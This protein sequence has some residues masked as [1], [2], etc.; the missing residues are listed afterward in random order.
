MFKWLFV[1]VA[2]SAITLRNLKMEND[3]TAGKLKITKAAHGLNNGDILLYKVN[4]GTPQTGL[5]DNKAYAV[6]DKTANTFTLKSVTNAEPPVA[7][8]KINGATINQTHQPTLQKMDSWAGLNAAVAGGDTFSVS[9]N[10]APAATTNKT[11]WAAGDKIVFVCTDSGGNKCDTTVPAAG[12]AVFMRDVTAATDSASLKFKI[13]A[14]ATGNALTVNQHADVDDSDNGFYKVSSAA[15]WNPI[16]TTTKAPSWDTTNNKLIGTLASATF[17]DNDLVW[18]AAST[19]AG[20]LTTNTI[21]SVTGSEKGLD[22][23]SMQFKAVNASLAAT[24]SAIGITSAGSGG[25]LRKVTKAG[26]SHIKT[27]A[28]ATSGNVTTDAN[29]SLTKDDEVR[30][31]CTDNSAAKCSAKLGGFTQNTSYWAQADTSD[32]TVKL[33]TTK[34]GT[35][36]KTSAAVTTHTESIYLVKVGAA[37]NLVP[38]PAGSGSAA[39][40][41]AMFGSAVGVLAAMIL[42]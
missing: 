33:K 39:R 13:A 4:G 36:Q 34:A 42:A 14:T 8:S 15:A 22:K 23:V 19:P 28:I 18:Y 35:A 26:G 1:P 5:A 16:T 29:A 41:L 6:A 40:G 27:T 10:G 30:F 17:S 3:A 12:T 11:T 32:K 25:S 38:A 21:Y 2:A 7:G 24:G 37:V 31:Y 9:N 20:G